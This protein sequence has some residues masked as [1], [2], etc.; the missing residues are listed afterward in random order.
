M[1]QVKRFKATTQELSAKGYT[2]RPSRDGRMEIMHISTGLIVGHFYAPEAV[3]AV[4]EWEDQFPVCEL[5]G[6][7]VCAEPGVN[8]ECDETG[9]W[10]VVHADCYADTLPYVPTDAE[11]AAEEAEIDA[12]REEFL[13]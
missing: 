6:D 2:F 12:A 10:T 5:C 7:I 9:G 13:R 3:A 11:L 8:W 1:N 4:K